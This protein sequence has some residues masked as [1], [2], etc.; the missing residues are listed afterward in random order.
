MT[1]WKRPPFFNVGHIYRIIHGTK[2]SSDRYVSFFLGGKSHQ[3]VPFPGVDLDVPT[4]RC[5]ADPGSTWR[6]DPLVAAVC[7]L[8][9]G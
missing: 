6:L 1:R 3:R 2:F 7:V 8:V 4:F 9:D 5:F